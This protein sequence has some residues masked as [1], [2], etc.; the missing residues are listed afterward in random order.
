MYNTLILPHFYYG[1]LLWG[2]K[3]K[4]LIKLQKRA[5]RTIT[6]SKYNAHSE[7][8]CKYLNT[9][10]LHDLYEL[11]LYK[12]YYKIKKGLVPHYLVTALPT[13][14]HEHYTRGSLTQDPQ[15]I[16]HHAFADHNCLV[17]MLVL[18]NKSPDIRTFILDCTNI[19]QFTSFVKV[20]LFGQYSY[21]CHILN[22]Y[23][24]TEN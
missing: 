22:C 5:L 7:P 3:S 15:F 6:L 11:Q 23:V 2:H 18:I 17:A 19:S 8:I 4:R 14:T 24:C 20:R 16:T 10:K 13:L 1:L 9:L 12:L 21:F